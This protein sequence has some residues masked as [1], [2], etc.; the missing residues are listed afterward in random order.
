MVQGRHLF[1]GDSF[2]AKNS[3][4]GVSSSS[5]EGRKLIWS[6]SLEREDS[7]ETLAPEAKAIRKIV[8]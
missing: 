3:K 8:F 2:F 5:P 6:L 1:C 7:S 4:A